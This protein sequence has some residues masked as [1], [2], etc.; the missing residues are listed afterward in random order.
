[1]ESA[2]LYH[3]PAQLSQEAEAYLEVEAVALNFLYGSR[4]I[5]LSKF[6]HFHIL[7]PK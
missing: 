5:Y 6:D 4:S 1:M 7:G 2:I 3:G